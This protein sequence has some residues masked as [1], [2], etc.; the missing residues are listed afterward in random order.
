MNFG[1][2]ISISRLNSTAGN[3]H[4]YECI[5]KDKAL[6]FIRETSI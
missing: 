6:K 4:N 1:E 5:V 2:Y 3:K